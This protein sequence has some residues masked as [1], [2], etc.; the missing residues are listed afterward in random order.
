[1][2]RVVPLHEVSEALGLSGDDV[3]EVID[4]CFAFVDELAYAVGLDLVLGFEAF[5]LFDFDFDPE[6]LTVVSVLEA[7]AVALHVSEAQEE[8]FVGS[9]PCVV[10]AHGVVCGD[11]AIDE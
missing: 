7:L 11:G 6:T 8:V 5:F 4:A 1:M 10:D 3:G 2:V 9:S